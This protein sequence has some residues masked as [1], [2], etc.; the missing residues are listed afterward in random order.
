MFMFFHA[1]IN[2]HAQIAFAINVRQIYDEHFQVHYRK[3]SL[4]GRRGIGGPLRIHPE[5]TAGSGQEQEHKDDDPSFAGLSVLR[6]LSW[7]RRHSSIQECNLR[8]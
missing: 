8:A 4:S 2:A 1:Q 6:C 7:L 3:R 5:S